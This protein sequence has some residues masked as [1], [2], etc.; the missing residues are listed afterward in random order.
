VALDWRLR[1]ATAA[2]R[3]FLLTLHR[4]T[5]REHVDAIWGWRDDEQA[6]MFDERF[7]PDRWQVVQAGGE[8]VGVLAVEERADELFL[9]NVQL[10]PAWQGRGL[11]TAILR[12]LLTRATE[13]GTPLTLTVLRSNRR[14]AALYAREGFRV[15]GETPER[16]SMRADPSLPR[17]CG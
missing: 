15:V 17:A 3:E 2:D 4:Q 14:A 6:R 12:A 11:G 10:L 16:I 5:M 7:T 1:P 8:D 9:A 13:R